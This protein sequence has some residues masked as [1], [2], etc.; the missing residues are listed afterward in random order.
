MWGVASNALSGAIGLKNGSMKQNQVSLDGSDDETCLNK[1]GED[2]LDCPICWESFNIVENVPYVLWCG[3]T[4][5]KNCVM[6]L[7][8]AV[9][10]LPTFPMQLPLFISCPWCNLFSLRLVYKGNVKYP[11]KNYFL[12]WMVESI[13]GDRS[14]SRFPS[15][16]SGACSTNRNSTKGNQVS[17]DGTTGTS[18]TSHHHR[19]HVITRYFR[20]G[21]QRIPIAVRN[22]LVFLMHLMVK[23]PLIIIFL[24]IVLYA[25]PASAVIL[26][27]YILVTLVFAVPSFLVLYCALPGLDWL[28]REIVS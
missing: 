15:H 11:C 14:K 4:L 7:Q 12:L 27:L 17:S 5:C 20:A 23:F 2:G 26:A 10:K 13:N 28:M 16:A 6:G 9:V 8:R 18:S 19:G 21:R 3:H 25:V 24:L 1:G 22:S